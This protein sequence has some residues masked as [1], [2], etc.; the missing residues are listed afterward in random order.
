MIEGGN[1]I[2]SLSAAMDGEL[3]ER[4][5]GGTMPTP[6]IAALDASVRFIRDV[7]VRKINAHETALAAELC[8]LL[9]RI[10]GSILRGTR[11]PETGIVLYENAN[12]SV[13]RIA[14][15]LNA[16][17]I[18]TRG[19]F[20]CC[21]LGHAALHTGKEGAIR[22]SMGYYNTIR[23]IDAVADAIGEICANASAK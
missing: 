2:N 6:A 5:E 1:G 14:D 22:I 13:N 18:C 9:S 8:R 16:R 23:D 15:G 12:V 19:G 3:P 11:L 20:H 17:D 21:P 4:F 7:G 10:P